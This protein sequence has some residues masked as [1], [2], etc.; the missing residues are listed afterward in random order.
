VQDQLDEV[1][2]RVV[3]AMVEQAK[4]CIA[5][6]VTASADDLNLTLALTGWAPHRGGPLR[7]G[8]E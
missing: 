1:R 4:R 5:E 8:A 7:C 3:G 2:R 6:R